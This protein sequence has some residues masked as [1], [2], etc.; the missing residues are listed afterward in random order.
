MMLLHSCFAVVLAAA[1][2]SL[3]ELACRSPK[4]SLSCWRLTQIFY[5]NLAN[6][7]LKLETRSGN[8]SIQSSAKNNLIYAYCEDSRPLSNVKR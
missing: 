5:V 3:P 6:V 1:V 2:Y 4:V 8:H 7:M